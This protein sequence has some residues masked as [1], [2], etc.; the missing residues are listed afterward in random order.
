MAKPAIF[1]IDDEIQVCNAVERDLRQEYAKDYRI[2]KATS[3]AEA[4]AAL[5]ALK[6]RNDQ[7][8]LFLC[9]QPM[10]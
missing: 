6:Q 1:A 3:G 2:M 10:P 4:L 9:D 7:V 8:A 5:H